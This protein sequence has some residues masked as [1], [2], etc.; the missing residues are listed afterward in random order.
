MK[1]ILVS[2][3]FFLI[4]QTPF[5]VNLIVVGFDEEK[6]QCEMY[7]MDYLAAMVKVPYA[8]HGYGGF[9]TTALMDRHYRP[10]K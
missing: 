1:Y 8:A 5:M 9:F 7:Y 3:I 2:T 10:G 6:E 4:F